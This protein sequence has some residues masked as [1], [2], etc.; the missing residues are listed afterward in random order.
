MHITDLP[1]VCYWS[2]DER[3]VL[4]RHRGFQQWLQIQYAEEDGE[5]EAYVTMGGVRYWVGT[6]YLYPR[7]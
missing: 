2:D 6:S 1:E 5:S 4:V 3:S 7:R